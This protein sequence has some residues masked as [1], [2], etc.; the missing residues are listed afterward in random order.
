M[1]VV[2]NVRAVEVMA[3]C[4]VCPRKPRRRVD[5]CV[6]LS[7][8][9]AIHLIPEETSTAADWLLPEPLSD[10]PVSDWLEVPS[11]AQDIPASP[12]RGKK[13]ERKDGSHLATSAPLL[14]STLVH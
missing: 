5:P 1:C 2:L 7:S 10:V 6:S 3:R 9:T 12:S 13:T 4:S 8:R 14:A 11:L